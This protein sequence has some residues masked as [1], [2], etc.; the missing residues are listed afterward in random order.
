MRR[1]YRQAVY[2][3]SS[4]LHYD[5]LESAIAP[6]KGWTSA[7]PTAADR[8]LRPHGPKRRQSH[9]WHNRAVLRTLERR[10]HRTGLNS[11]SAFRACKDDP[12]LLWSG[13]APG[14]S[15]LQ[16]WKIANGRLT[17]TPLGA[18]TLTTPS[19]GSHRRRR[20]DPARLRRTMAA[21]PLSLNLYTRDHCH[22][23]SAGLVAL[24]LTRPRWPALMVAGWLSAASAG[25]AP[26]LFDAR[27]H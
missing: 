5:I 2:T 10:G 4:L 8:A 11:R 6:S 26:P 17:N 15:A 25:A 19:R 24:S 12:R 20:A 1:A 3:P 16:R 7:P 21:R 23:L 18:G 14:S 9:F 27:P 22:R 13:V